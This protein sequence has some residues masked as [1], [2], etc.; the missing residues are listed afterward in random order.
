M[1]HPKT[2]STFS[3]KVEWLQNEKH[4]LICDTQYAEDSKLERY[5]PIP[6]YIL[7]SQKSGG[8]T[9]QK[10]ISPLFTVYVCAPNQYNPSPDKI[11]CSFNV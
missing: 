6:H 10:S 11:S 1:L 5:Y 7:I 3:E 4:L 8:Y 2:F 9:P